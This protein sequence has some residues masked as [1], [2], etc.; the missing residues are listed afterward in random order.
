MISSD[1]AAELRAALSGVV[2]GGGT[3][4]TAALQTYEVAGKTGTARRA[5]PEG[6]IEG[7]YTASFASLFPADD[8]QLVMVVKLDDPNETYAQATAAPLTRA[9]LEQVLAAQTAALDHTRLGR[10]TPPRMDDFEAGAG[11]APFVTAWPPV[12]AVDSV[13]EVVIPD[14]VGMT[15]REV[16]RILHE[17]RLRMNMSGWGF[18]ASTDPEA[19]TLVPEGTVIGVVGVWDSGASR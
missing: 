8:P 10:A 2:Y 5:G 11:D 4:E 3:A 18:A 15:L 12:E 19:G 9:V 13:G 17:N 1:V 7:S 6:Y 16:A 14:V